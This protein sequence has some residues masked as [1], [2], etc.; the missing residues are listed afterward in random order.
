[1]TPKIKGKVDDFD[2]KK[3]TEKYV[4]EFFVKFDAV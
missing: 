1:M 2:K 4:Q 3:L